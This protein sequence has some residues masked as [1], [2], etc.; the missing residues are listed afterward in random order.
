MFVDPTGSALVDWQARRRTIAEDNLYYMELR[1]FRRN[2]LRWQWQ[3]KDHHRRMVEAEQGCTNRRNEAHWRFGLDW[4]ER[5]DDAA[6]GRPRTTSEANFWTVARVAQAGELYG[7]CLV[8]GRVARRAAMST[9][10]ARNLE[11]RAIQTL[12]NWLSDRF[13]FG[14]DARLRM[15]VRMLELAKSSWWT[16]GG[17]DAWCARSQYMELERCFRVLWGTE[18]TPSQ[19]SL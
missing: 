17:L 15:Q 1:R 8:L 5:V 6:W 10:N 9:S 12:R 7:E 4:E 16:D 3:V 2:V 14:T 13:G 19:P 11:Q 18:A